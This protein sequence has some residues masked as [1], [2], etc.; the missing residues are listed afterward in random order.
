MDRTRLPARIGIILPWSFPGKHSHE[1]RDSLDRAK[2]QESGIGRQ[3]HPAI[4]RFSAFIASEFLA[5][6]EKGLWCLKT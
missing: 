6:R 3:R 2:L 4:R 5:P 1:D